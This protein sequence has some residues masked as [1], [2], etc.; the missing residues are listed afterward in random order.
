MRLIISRQ[1]LIAKELLNPPRLNSTHADRKSHIQG[2][3]MMMNNLSTIRNWFLIPSLVELKEVILTDANILRKKR[4]LPWIY[5]GH[6]S[7]VWAK[8]DS[9]DEEADHVYH[10][11]DSNDEIEIEKLC[12]L[13]EGVHSSIWSLHEASECPH[14]GSSNVTRPRL[15]Q[16][17]CHNCYQGRQA[18]SI[19]YVAQNT[20]YRRLL[21]PTI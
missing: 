8:T 5:I 9:G 21:I 10:D 12:G 18:L 11:E 3:P 13:K 2:I 16:E 4:W 15:I 7:P 20:F 19:Q 1:S 14:V 17:N 6:V